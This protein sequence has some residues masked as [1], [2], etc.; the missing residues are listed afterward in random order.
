MPKADVMRVIAVLDEEARAISDGDIDG[1]LAILAEDAVFMPPNLFEK[2]GEELRSWLRDFLAGF[3]AVW[4]KY[5]H[6]QTEVVGDLAYHV[7]F[8]SWRVTP[9]A[10]GA[11][12]LGHGK[13]IHI[14]RRQPDGSWKLAREIW[15][16]SPAAS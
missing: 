11:G 10:G 7:F 16:P 8:Y 12:T 14:L 15:T 9:K 3:T 6:G 2:T 13:G 5:V 1:L 4:L